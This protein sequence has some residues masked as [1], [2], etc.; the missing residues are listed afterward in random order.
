M[1]RRRTLPGLTLRIVL[2]PDY[3]GLAE[4]LR[5]RLPAAE[6]VAVDRSEL[7]RALDAADAVVTDR[8][9]V[10][11]TAG[12]G[13]LRLVHSYSAGA[14]RI[15]RAALPNGCALCNLHGP[16]HAIAEWVLG[17]MVALSRRLLFHDRELR[18]GL[19]HRGEHRPRELGGRLVGVVGYGP[20]GRRVVEL[21]RAVGMETAAVTRSPSAERA[22]GL[23]W[24]G[25]LREV[26]RLAAAADFLVVAL[27]L[28]A[29]TRGLI[30]RAELEALGTDGYLLNVGR[31]EVVDEGAL[32]DALRARRVAGAA[33]DVW[34][35]YPRGSPAP[36]LPSRF[37][38]HELDNV[39]MSPHASGTTVETE[40]R[41]RAIL[42]AQLERFARGE[43]LE[44]VIAVGR[45][46]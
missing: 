22:A 10:E 32:Y 18:R 19:W 1:P 6:I 4:E 11:D 31:G 14:D 2:A 13:R 28:T 33:L 7:P 9:T 16:E 5:S 30:G 40:R 20:I 34:Y 27:P 43:P 45:G 8:L 15:D 36:T 29:E 38:F 24:L 25:D 23:R 12:A 41:R 44:H 26:Q 37:P 3:H 46:R 39:L 35:C 17:A 42:L 21:C